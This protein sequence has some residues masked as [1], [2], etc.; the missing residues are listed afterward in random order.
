LNASELR[1]RVYYDF[2]STL[3]YV[4]HRALARLAEPIA[5]LGI[6]LDWSPLDLT[7]LVGGHRAGAAI[8]ELR[9]ANA[10]RV[11]EE[12]NVAVQVPRVWPEARALGA[13]ALLAEPL[14]RGASWRERAFSAVFEEHALV[15]DAAGAARLAGELA[16]ELAPAA[17]EAAL[18]TLDANTARAREEQVTGVP[19][20][21]LGAWPFG[22]IQSDDTM[23]RVLGRFAAKARERAPG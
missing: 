8:H 4:A 10:A 23:L 20:F 14:G 17:I 1:V 15:L 7:R 13:A 22:G 21:M 11:A 12:L 6:A 19:T 9:R 2:A 16:L 3:C 18:A 5:E